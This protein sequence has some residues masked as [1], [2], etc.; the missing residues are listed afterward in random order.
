MDKIERFDRVS[1][2]NNTRD[3]Y[4]RSALAYHLD[5][6]VSVGERREHT[7]CDTDEV[8]HMFS[9]KREDRHVRMD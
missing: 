9:D 5:V 2:I 6:H 4:L 8:P 1:P 7:T 3:V